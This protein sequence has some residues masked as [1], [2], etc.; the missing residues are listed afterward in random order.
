M[1]TGALLLYIKTLRRGMTVGGFFLKKINR[2]EHLT[3]CYRK[4][5]NHNI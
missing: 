2:Y 5:T 4:V 1:K 3:S